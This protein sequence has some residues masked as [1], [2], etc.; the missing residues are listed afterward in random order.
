MYNFQAIISK[1]TNNALV[2]FERFGMLAHNLS[3]VDT[4]G[5]K[6]QTFEQILKEDGYLTGS[7]RTDYS[8]GSVRVTENPYDVAID[9]PG[10]IP[11]T[12]PTGEVQYTRDGAFRLGKDGYLLTSDGWMVGDGI[13]IPANCYKF[14][15]KKNGEVVAYDSHGDKAKKLGYIPLIQFDNPDGM[16]QTDMDR[17]I[18]TEDAGQGRLVKNHDFFK[19]ACLERANV[20]VYSTANDLL[21]LNASMLASMQMLKVADQMYN[22]A[23]NIREG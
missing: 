20:S 14:V 16:E 10:Y 9:G 4:N 12:S 21:R 17:L 18:A 2:Q 19:Q 15:I 3:N 8:Q 11:V 6:K 23:I 13:K 1:G 5:Y 7:V 22:K